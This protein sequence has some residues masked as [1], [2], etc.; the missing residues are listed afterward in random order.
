MVQQYVT[1]TEKGKGAR[2][3][4]RKVVYKERGV[5]LGFINAMTSSHFE[6]LFSFSKMN[7]ILLEIFF[8]AVLFS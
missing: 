6:H 8:F 4:E 5:N 2:K 3:G 1:H 7:S